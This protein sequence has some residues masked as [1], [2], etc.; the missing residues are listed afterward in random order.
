MT[1]VWV[2]VA[3]V[4]LVCVLL[5]A[6]GPL[7]VR[8][9]FPPKVDRWLQL[10]APALLAAFVAVQTLG[11]EHRLTLDARLAGV[12]AAAL[13]ILT[14]R[15]PLLVLLVAAGATAAVRALW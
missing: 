8:Q 13:A 10:L 5:R 4:S 11:S 15:S 3:L 14:G 2:A 12:A 1:T 7:L 9:P 6:A